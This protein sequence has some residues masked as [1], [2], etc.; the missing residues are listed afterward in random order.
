MLLHLQICLAA[1][2]HELNTLGSPPSSQFRS[3]TA[4]F[5]SAVA[6]PIFLSG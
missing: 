6:L 2:Y 1:T 3:I 4:Y 5:F